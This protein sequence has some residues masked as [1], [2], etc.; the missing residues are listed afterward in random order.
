MFA[1]GKV[2][3]ETTV[4]DKEN[5]VTNLVGVRPMKFQSKEEMKVLET[6]RR[7]PAVVK[8]KS[9]KRVSAPRMSARD[10]H[11]SPSPPKIEYEQKSP[12]KAFSPVAKFR[13]P[14]VT[15]DEC[16]SCARVF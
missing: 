10:S 9:M 6:S 14:A 12:N 8:E 2:D 1:S 15:Q 13:T 4:T 11:K 16:M 7:F 5:I 3:V